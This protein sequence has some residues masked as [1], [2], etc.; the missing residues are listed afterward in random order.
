M[1]V[2]LATLDELY[3]KP[4]VHKTTSF[5]KDT[6]ISSTNLTNLDT[7]TSLRTGSRLGWV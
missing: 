1:V 5:I 4:L 3:L 7:A 6:R 2:L